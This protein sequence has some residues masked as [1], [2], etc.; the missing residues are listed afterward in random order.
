L[1]QSHR[2]G[3]ASLDVILVS[4][5]SDWHAAMRGGLSTSGDQYSSASSA[6]SGTGKGVR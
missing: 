3:K 4:L 1:R 2:R 6:R 5:M